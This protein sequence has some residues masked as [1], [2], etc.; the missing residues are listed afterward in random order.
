MSWLTDLLEEQNPDLT[1]DELDELEA[2]ILEEQRNDERCD[3]RM[4]N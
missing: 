2:E 1:Q 3:E 4:G